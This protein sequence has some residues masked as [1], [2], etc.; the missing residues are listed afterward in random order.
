MFGRL[1]PQVLVLRFRC[2]NPAHPCGVWKNIKE[3]QVPMKSRAKSGQVVQS[4][5]KLLSS[6]KISSWSGVRG[7]SA[8]CGIYHSLWHTPPIKIYPG[9]CLRHGWVGLFLCPFGVFSPQFYSQLFVQFEANLCVE[10]SCGL[11]GFSL[12]LVGIWALFRPWKPTHPLSFST[13]RIALSTLKSTFL[14]KRKMSNADAT[15]L[16]TWGKCQK[17]KWFHFH[18]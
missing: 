15:N 1:L 2:S 18:A 14:F 6:R 12:C 9:S 11:V 4:R 10:G 5:G 17:D 7:A 16:Q 3:S 13:L 8:F